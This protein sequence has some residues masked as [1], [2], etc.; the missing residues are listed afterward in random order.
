MILFFFLNY[1]LI[2]L[3]FSAIA[4]IFY[5]IEKLLVPIG[6]PNKEEKAEVERHPVFVKATVL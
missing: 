6:I 1:W 3:I 2:L 4:Q 5:P